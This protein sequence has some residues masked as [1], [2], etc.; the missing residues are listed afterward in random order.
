MDSRKIKSGIYAMV[1]VTLLAFG[2]CS[3][4]VDKN[5]NCLNPASSCYVPDVTAPGVTAVSIYKDSTLA[6]PLATGSLV[7]TLYAIDITFS[8]VMRNA[9][10][11]DQ[12]KF[13]A[14]SGDSLLSVDSVQKL[15]D[16][17]YRYIVG[18]N[19]RN[20]TIRL[21]SSATDVS[22]KSL[23]TAAGL[24]PIEMTGSVNVSVGVVSINSNYAT[25]NTGSTQYNEAVIIW[26]HDYLPDNPGANLTHYYVMLNAACN[27][28]GSETSNLTETADGSNF[29][30][31]DLDNNV[32]V[33]TTVKASA[34]TAGNN[35]LYI[36]VR[37]TTENKAG[38]AEI[39]LVRDDTLPESRLTLASPRTGNYAAVQ[40]IE[41]ECT[42]THCE[43]IAYTED[44][45]DP[46]FSLGSISNGSAYT[47]PWQTPY[48]VDPTTT[49]FKFRA[50]DRAGNV[51][52]TVHEYT[53]TI[54]TRVP[55]LTLSSNLTR[56]YMKAGVDTQ[57]SMQSSL[58][59]VRQV[60]LDTAECPASGDASWS[61]ATPTTQNQDYGYTYTADTSGADFT[62]EGVHN[63][64]V[65][66]KES[67]TG[68]NYVGTLSRSV[69]VDFT[70]PK[71][72]DGSAA[73][74]GLD[75]AE[76]V[77]DDIVLKWTAASD[78]SPVYYDIYEATTAGG[79]NFSSASYSTENAGF[80]SN[81]SV[82]N[83]TKEVS[84]T[85]GGKDITSFYFYVV[86]ARDKAGNAESNTTEMRAGKAVTVKL[87][88]LPPSVVQFSLTATGTNPGTYPLTV[89]SI[90]R[91][92]FSPALQSGDTY[93]VKITSM[94]A[95][96]V[97]AIE[98]VQYGTVADSN[99][100]L[101]VECK[102]G[103]MLGG[104]FQELKAVRLNYH[105]YRG[106][107]TRPVLDWSAVSPNSF[108]APAGLTVIGSDRYIADSWNNRILKIDASNQ[109]SQLTINVPQDPATL[110]YPRYPVTD[111]GSIYFSDNGNN[112]VIKIKPDGTPLAVYDTGAGP[113]G[114]ALDAENQILYVAARGDAKIQKIDLSTGVVSDLFS[115][116][117][118]SSDPNGLALLEGKLY[119]G[120]VGGGHG[121]VQITLTPT[122]TA[123]LF[124][125]NAASGFQD[126]EKLSAR[127]FNPLDLATDGRDLYVGEHGNNRVRKINMRTGIVST[128]AGSGTV[129]TDDGIGINATFESVQSIS[130][131]GRKL[132]IVDSTFAEITDTGLV[133][134]WPLNGTAKDY[135]SDGAIENGMLH[136]GPSL[137]EDRHGQANEAY[138]FNGSD[139]ELQA[140]L[141]ADLPTGLTLSVCAWIKPDA[142][143]VADKQMGI[144]IF[145]S[146]LGGTDTRF[147]G[148]F[149]VAG[150]Q[151]IGFTGNYDAT[152]D[153][154]VSAPYTSVI[155]KWQHICGVS[156]KIGT[157]S[158]SVSLYV[159]G[160]LIAKNTPASDWNNPINPT[161]P[162]LRIGRS[163]NNS[164]FNGSIADVRIYHRVLSESEINV[165][166][167]DADPGL[168]SDSYNAGATGLLSHYRFDYNGGDPS[169]LDSGPLSYSLTKGNN[170]TGKPGKDGDGK[171][172]FIFNG[173]GQYLETTD[174]TG[175]PVGGHP[176]TLCAWIKPSAY[177]SSDGKRVPFVSINND[178]KSDSNFDFGLQYETD[179]YELYAG[180]GPQI[181]SDPWQPP[182]Y[183]WSH[184]CVSYGS[185][186]AFFV[187]GQRITGHGSS[188]NTDSNLKFK[189]AAKIS[190]DSDE[191]HFTG[192]IDDV[193]IYNNV[194][195]GEQIRQLASQIPAGLVAR[196]DFTD[197]GGNGDS[198]KDVSGFG[199]SLTNNGA[200][201]SSDRF[202][203]QK[204]AYM[205]NNTSYLTNTS[206][207]LPLPS[208][209]QDRTICGWGSA[210]SA[211][212]G[213]DA[214]ASYG[215][216]SNNDATS[217]GFYDIN[218]DDASPYGGVFSQLLSP[219]AK[220]VY[221]N[222]WHFVCFTI[223]SNT[224]TLYVNGN[225]VRTDPLSPPPVTSSGPIQLG[226]MGTAHT[227][228][229]TGTIDEVTIYNRALSIDEIRALTNQPNKRILVTATSYNGNL[230]GIS[231]ADSICGAGYKA[232]IVD[233]SG[234]GGSACRKACTSG[235]CSTNGIAEHIDWVLRPNVTYVRSDG[236]TPIFTANWNVVF[237]FD[238]AANNPSRQTSLANKILESGP[239][240]WTGLQNN[241]A[242]AWETTSMTCDNWANTVSDGIY[243]NSNATTSS[244]LGVNYMSC[245]SSLYLYCVEQ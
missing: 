39:S 144:V 79:Q 154:L 104:T 113:S 103:Y 183:N 51:E 152:P 105:L 22:G 89:N 149:N 63:I 117:P 56:Q 224:M 143:P 167:Q 134:Y 97:C 221:T 82:N 88:S 101:G 77:S 87:A 124:A 80:A 30:S 172:A 193:R 209:S 129:G 130:S 155:G 58:T 136:N 207:S 118:L 226:R 188:I 132:Y 205:T 73:F 35:T 23:K 170:P 237:D 177:P 114:L 37:N 50:V 59:G 26:N 75:S 119:V 125:G 91:T 43:R 14:G 36:C 62:S 18:G 116:S 151:K 194:L 163:I 203:Q 120:S 208:G 12:F 44:S 223:S 242:D 32:N 96:Y 195:T 220:Y 19:V 231:G 94:P 122:V 107:V 175:L 102:E 217:I 57:F 192:I 168:S 140:G 227:Y 45:T 212:G 67:D 211:V 147:L 228:A 178:T 197:N 145:G 8:E 157:A 128:I 11:T 229:L 78:A 95:G 176:R 232:M 98:Q 241:A 72:Q 84:C 121:I 31:A 108:N 71:A 174:A 123:D 15:S 66:V 225:E 158:Q 17:K 240:S 25:V 126:G 6:N 182:L 245:G 199:N 131:D 61:G 164:Y 165:L 24:Y 92:A 139:Q 52:A 34:L 244:I 42:D 236:L 3:Y 243:G 27:F 13:T 70:V 235:N 162:T 28:G 106:K 115:G 10:D 206:T 146:S 171:G 69:M 190:D 47:G 46:A 156:E 191:E 41:A 186:A 137:A 180:T 216:V 16:T 135:N 185:S 160:H 234:C 189:I 181:Y 7:N 38:Y 49:T 202:G 222:V 150:V 169:I 214:I 93:S 4:E 55:V 109:V 112:R 201:Q 110:L 85:I 173:T 48:S 142:R 138:R 83:I 99:V 215:S 9:D 21:E 100:D 153:Y 20:G 213:V 54:D 179:H 5:E 161:N 219:L 90:D 133:G 65:C 2:S 76:I 40:I 210:S 218:G 239:Y 68:L 233:E 127:F 74:A 238:T 200:V 148:L 81:C 60:L 187:N 1:T 198:L 86:R 196:Y 29:S 33:T 184:V 141:S 166:A 111:G 159:N 230:G 64:L 204:S 53:Y